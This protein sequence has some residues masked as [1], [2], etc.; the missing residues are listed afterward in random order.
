MQ[1]PGLD[2]VTLHIYSPPIRKMSTYEFK[3][4]AGAECADKY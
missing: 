1:A 2:L 4:S 3:T